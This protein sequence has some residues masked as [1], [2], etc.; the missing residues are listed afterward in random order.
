MGTNRPRR[1]ANFW[2]AV[3]IAISLQSAP[4]HALQCPPDRPGCTPAPT[5]GSGGGNVGVQVDVGSAAKAIGGIFK[6]KKKKP[7]EQKPADAAMPAPQVEQPKPEIIYVPSTGVVRPT[8]KRPAPKVAVR[9]R[10][11]TPTPQIRPVAKPIVKTVRR[12]VA[13]AVLPTIAA[14]APDPVIEPAPVVAEPVIEPVIAAVPDPVAEPAAPVVATSAAPGPAEK[15]NSNLGFYAIIAAAMAAAVGVASYAA[16]A[17][18]AP[19]VG[20]NCALENPTTQMV[21]MPTASP[22][23]VTF[24]AVVPGISVN[25]PDGLSIAT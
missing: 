16:K 8:P 21:S 7:V 20:I 10:V 22:P 18:F 9:P 2:A 24:S 23:E 12:V 17:L 14:K 19:K 6:K 3:I 11:I 1:A 25:A 5:G 13:P 4:A 15:T